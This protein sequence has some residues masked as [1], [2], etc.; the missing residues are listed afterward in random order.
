MKYN[1]VEVFKT[2]Q[3][4]GMLQGVPSVFIRLY[5]CNLRCRWCDTIYTD[6][7]HKYDVMELEVLIT[8]IDKFNCSHVVITGGEPFLSPGIVELTDKLREKDYHIT[9]ETNGTI[10]KEISCDLL[11]ISPKLNNSV[12]SN[13]SEQELISYN[14]IRKN[15]I[16]LNKLISRYEYQFKFVII[17]PDEILE[18]KDIVNQLSLNEISRNFIMP[19][20]NSRKE[21][22]ACQ[23]EFIKLCIEHNFRYA[24]RL[25]LQV[26]DIDEE[27]IT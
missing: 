26:W 23:K 12:P 1:I 21:L 14:L 4:E 9:I 2:I 8:K 13:L 19:A 3:G 7:Y 11:S 5:G 6:E 18:A 25:Q 24:N 27:K 10:Y 16:V 22:F 20:T 17:N 15:M